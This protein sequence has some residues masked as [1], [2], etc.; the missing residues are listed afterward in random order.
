[1][2][3]GGQLDR[4]DL[5]TGPA[6][7]AAVLRPLDAMMRFQAVHD[8]GMGTGVVKHGGGRRQR[9]GVAAAAAFCR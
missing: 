6:V 9:V 3:A 8:P 5:D 2:G 4:L 7:L 1:M